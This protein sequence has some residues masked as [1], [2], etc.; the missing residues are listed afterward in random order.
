MTELTR[1]AL[2]QAI[3]SLQ[4]AVNRLESRVRVLETGSD[5]V[6]LAGQAD[7][8][9]LV[10]PRL[11]DPSPARAGFSG[12]KFWYLAGRSVLVLAGAFL[13]RFMSDAGTIPALGG[14]LAGLGYCLALIWMLHRAGGRNDGIGA[15]AHGLTAAVIAFP[16]IAESGGTRAL[17]SPLG[18][19][20]GLALV[21]GA[22]MFA[23]WR[24]RL[25]F[26]AWTFTL[27]ALMVV[28]TLIKSKEAYLESAS[29]LLLLGAGTCLLA[30][31]RHWHLKRWVVAGLLNVLLLWLVV[32][33]SG[34]PG[35]IPAGIHPFR[36][37]TL[38]VCH[39]L[40]Y[41]G[42]FTW[43]ALIQ[44]R[45][46]RVFDVVQSVGAVAVGFGGAVRIA[47]TNG[48]GAVALGWFALLS[49]LAGYAVAF[50][51]IRSRRGRGRGFFYFASLALVFLAIGSLTVAH[52]SWLVWC[53]VLLGLAAAG[54]GAAFRR[55]TLRF[56]AAVYLFL[57]AV[58]SGLARSSF[59]TFMSPP[60]S[61]RTGTDLPSAVVMLAA[62]AGYLIMARGH[63]EQDLSI[64][65]VIPRFFPAAMF[66]G[67]V[68]QLLVMGLVGLS[69]GTPP[70][71]DPALTALLRTAVLALTAVLLAVVSGR[72][73]LPELSWLVYPVLLFAC[74]KLVL[75]DLQVGNALTLCVGFALLGAALIIAPRT[76]RSRIPRVPPT[77]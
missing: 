16:L 27:G 33:A 36:V 50:I 71:P 15:V 53:W 1:E 26:L 35:R 18:A 20:G 5:R 60:D 30:Y 8:S 32:A 13:L 49:A 57:A 23:A 44:G 14:A 56:H 34:D 6:S 9:T 74:V 40:V 69:A 25:R 43:R 52:G 59:A 10:T 45:G 2:L 47:Q 19:V 62:L 11:P 46:V 63:R 39:L 65:L 12:A 75:E 77:G 61:I 22:G 73:A 64:A 24:R 38:A 4:A 3:E 67:G 72:L 54:L 28:V 66:L 41:L 29:F 51:F 21:T 7:A 17:L 31:S 37:Q 48:Q 55:V 42:I 58:G 70:D 68:G 76:A